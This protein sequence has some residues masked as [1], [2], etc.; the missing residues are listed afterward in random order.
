[1]PDEKTDFERAQEFMRQQMGEML[2]DMLPS[3]IQAHQRSQQKPS[4]EQQQLQQAHQAVRGIVQPDLDRANLAS[5]NAMDMINFYGDDPMAREYQAEVEATARIL[6]Q[7]GRPTARKDI[8]RHTLGSEMLNDPKKFEERQGKV[9]KLQLARAALAGDIGDGAEGRTT[10]GKFDRLDTLSK[11][12]SWSDDDMKEL[13][14]MLDGEV[15]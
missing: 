7:N 4:T 13:E 3:A 12:K 2:P 6:E 5:A 1:M 10:A 8:L 14:S 11:Q 15:F 9:R